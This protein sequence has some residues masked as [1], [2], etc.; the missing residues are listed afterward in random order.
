MLTEALEKGKYVAD[1]EIEEAYKLVVHLEKELCSLQKKLA[2]QET[3]AE[4]L[5]ALMTSKKVE[6]KSWMDEHMRMEEICKQ[7]EFDKE[8]LLQDIMKLSIER[9]NLLVYIQEICD[10]VGE[11]S[12]ED[13]EM[14]KVLQK[15][16]ARSEEDNQQATDLMALYDSTGEN[17][18]T[19]F[20]AT[21]KKLEASRNERSPLKEVNQ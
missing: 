4:Q 12:S 2:H 3:E 9:E 14:M 20:S 10:L 6:T 13:V 11:I 1:I 7:L 8:V 18:D 17:A 15:M 19:S 21:T 16:L 5:E